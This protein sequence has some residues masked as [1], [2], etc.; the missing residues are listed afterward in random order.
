MIV[1][2]IL[3]LFL[4]ITFHEFAHGWVASKLGDPTPKQSGR[5]TLNP[6]AHIDPF[7]TIALPILLLIVSGG[8]FAIGYAKPVPINPYHFKNPKKDLKLVGAAGPCANIILAIFLTLIYKVGIPVLANALI[9]GIAINLMLAIFNLVP[10]PPLD[11]SRIVASLLPTQMAYK[12][13]KLEPYGFF[14]IIL[15]FA[16][17]F[18]RWFVFPLVSIIFRY[19]LGIDLA[20]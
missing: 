12:Y 3:I 11:G 13:L 19:L 10:I 14:I 20:I 9:L 6:M 15:L 4:S 16:L 5:L 7:G 8:S 17:G 18:F 1:F 2:V